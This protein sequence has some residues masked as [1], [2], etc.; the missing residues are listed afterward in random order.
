MVSTRKAY[1]GTRRKLV[2]AFDVGTT[3]SGVSYSILDPGVVP[4]IRGVTRFP[5]QENVGGDCKIPSLLYYDKNGVVQAAGAEAVRDEVLTLKEDE[6]W[7]ATPWFKLHLRPNTIPSNEMSGK[8]PPLPPN[9]TAVQ[10]LSDFLRYLYQCSRTYIEETHGVGTNWWST[11]E[12]NVDFV[13]SHPNGWE[14][15]QQEQMR[16]AAILAGLVKTTS[17]AE[18]RISF[19]TEGE[20]SLHFCL[21]SGL[22]S[23]AMKD[24]SGVLIVDAGGG[25]VDMS[26][27]ARAD[28]EDWFEEIAAPQCHFQGSIFVTFN[29]RNFLEGRL[30][31][32][33]F[34]ED[35]PHITECFDKTTKLRFRGKNDPQYIRFGGVRDKDLAYGIR[36]GQLRLEGSDVASF[37]EPPIACILSSVKEQILTAHKPIHSVFLVGGFAASDY[38]YNQL[39]EDLSTLGLNVLRPDSHVNKAVADGAL[40]YYLDHRVGSRVSRF[41]YGVNCHVPYNPHDEE[42]QLRSITSWFSPSGN[43]RLPGFFSVILPK[44]TQVSEMKEFR[45]SYFE[46]SDYL[47]NFSCVSVALDCYRGKTGNPKWTDSSHPSLSHI[48]IL[49]FPFYSRQF[50]HRIETVL[51]TD[52]IPPSVI[53]LSFPDLTGNYSTLC[54]VEVDLSQMGKALGPHKGAG[55]HMYYKAD[56]DIVLLFG[57]TELKAQLS[58]KEK[59]VEKRS[60]ARIVYEPTRAF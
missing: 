22:P 16:H 7:I 26:A 24:G 50:Y 41:T 39:K 28:T 42:H 21:H 6:E 8:I 18:S 35:V 44:N 40:S 57:L 27:Y 59:G 52:L 55:G 13:L 49:P 15:A 23:D 45:R 1:T 30:R 3:Y 25:T 17:E 36:S 4:E 37:F 48:F 43:R 9:K 10:V 12:G 58:W 32:S 60:P 33:K 5:A 34:A 51:T 20:A 14:G 53:V 56:F 19:V 54:K 29:A 38:L 2:L 31:N 46:E 47:S 11:V